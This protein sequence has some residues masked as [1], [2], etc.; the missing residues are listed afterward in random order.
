M[1][2]IGHGLRV[3]L[4]EVQSGEIVEERFWGRSSGTLRVARGSKEHGET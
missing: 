2:T 1:A 3:D 4:M